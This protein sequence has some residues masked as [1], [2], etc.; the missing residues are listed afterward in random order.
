MH[1]QSVSTMMICYIKHLFKS[2]TCCETSFLCNGCLFA[3]V[4]WFY[5]YTRLVFV[6]WLY[7]II[8]HTLNLMSSSHIRRSR[9]TALQCKLQSRGWSWGLSRGVRWGEAPQ[10]RLSLS[11]FVYV[12]QLLSLQFPLVHTA[13]QFGAHRLNS[14]CT[15]TLPTVI[16]WVACRAIITTLWMFHR[17]WTPWFGCH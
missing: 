17:H 15:L 10:K 1:F 9:A 4:R 5:A 13:A 11:L 12:V 2:I 8:L 6:V 14:L 3:H 7:V 16:Y